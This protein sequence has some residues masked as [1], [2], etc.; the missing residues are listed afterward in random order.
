MTR[1]Q[2]N[3]LLKKIWLSKS[4]PN[5]GE[6]KLISGN[7]I[8][9]WSVGLFLILALI[10]LHFSKSSYNNTI[11]ISLKH[12]ANIVKELKFKIDSG[13]KNDFTARYREQQINYILSPGVLQNAVW[14]SGYGITYFEDKFPLDMPLYN[15]SSPVIISMIK[16]KN[17]D[18]K[19]LNIELYGKDYFEISI[20][21]K[22]SISA[23]NKSIS[24]DGTEFIVKKTYPKMQSGQKV[25][26]KIAALNS[27][28]TDLR[29]LLLI[30]YPLADSNKINLSI[31][32]SD[33]VKAS[34]LLKS[35]RSI[36]LNTSPDSASLNSI[37]FINLKLDS[38]KQ[39][40]KKYPALL[41]A[42]KSKKSIKAVERTDKPIDKPVLQKQAD[43][44]KLISGY[45]KIPNNQ[46]SFVPNTFG[47]KDSEL[48][49]SVNKL[50]DDQIERQKLLQ[51]EAPTSPVLVSEN[52]EIAYL[53]KSVQRRIDSLNKIIK[54]A[55]KNGGTLT[56]IVSNLKP[57]SSKNA[58]N[59]IKAEQQAKIALSFYLIQKRESVMSETAKSTKLRPYES[60]VKITPLKK[61]IVPVILLA[62]FAGLLMPIPF[63]LLTKQSSNSLT[64]ND[65]LNVTKIPVLGSLNTYSRNKRIIS[66][67]EYDTPIGQQILVI[68]KNVET[69]KN[70]KIIIVASKQSG[71]GKSFVAR[72]MAV[73]LSAQGKSVLYI[74]TGLIRVS[75]ELVV[76]NVTKDLSAFLKDDKMALDNI[77]YKSNFY[78]LSVIQCGN[79]NP[80][81]LLANSRM[82]LLLKQAKLTYDHIVIDTWSSNLQDLNTL[83]DKKTNLIIN[84]LNIK[85]ASLSSV[86][87][88][89]N[90]YLSLARKNVYLILNFA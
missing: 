37:K 84:V 19:R 16:N 55:L 21:D 1:E 49:L 10:F 41:A 70:N 23:Y 58:V 5:R 57:D 53:K 29:N 7:S 77:A 20:N 38:L 83:A 22:K 46:F 43:I 73:A 63:K 82:V 6:K 64:I 42:A 15:N 66:P 68:K 61:P 25:I 28:F 71:D 48:E 39:D 17:S 36:Y 85:T 60:S 32:L 80:A 26:I 2:V 47:L 79:E 51:T 12:K 14:E 62:V 76:K 35:I 27:Y 45:L 81:N 3:V 65:I 86:Q 30:S 90:H 4:Y 44:Y 8:Y 72:N 59:I 40:L 31:K 78:S 89:N 52:S 54:V 75:D 9:S 87:D 11:Q 33:T 13:K 74:Q 18:N 24:E 88:L 69:A 67:I 56:A 34:M 50:N